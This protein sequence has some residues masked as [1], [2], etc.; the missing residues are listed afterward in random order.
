MKPKTKQMKPIKFL[1]LIFCVIIFKNA[2]SQNI[3]KLV[4][5]QVIWNTGY[6]KIT[7]KK[8]SNFGIEQPDSLTLE[9][10][11]DVETIKKYSAEEL[12]FEYKWY[13]YLSTKKRLMDTQQVTLNTSNISEEDSFLLSSTRKTLNKGWWEVQIIALTDNG[14]IELGD[15]TQF[16]IFIK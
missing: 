14:L 12:K 2:N 16:Q 13:Y 5:I 10:F 15:I 1:L 3:S 4:P 8:A 9:V 6:D 11:F 7:L